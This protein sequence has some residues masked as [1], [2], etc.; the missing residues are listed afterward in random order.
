MVVMRNLSIH[1]LQM[2]AG[3]EGVAV[4]TDFINVFPIEIIGPDR[5]FYFVILCSKN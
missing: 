5:D 2:L 4:N 1:E 3:G